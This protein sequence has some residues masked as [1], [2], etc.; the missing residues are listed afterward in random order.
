M[1]FRRPERPSE[2][3]AAGA[4][5]KPPLGCREKEADGRDF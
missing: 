1:M 3:R 5:G 4:E 2:I